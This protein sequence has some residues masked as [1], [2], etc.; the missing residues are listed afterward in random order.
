MSNEEL[1]RFVLK[2]PGYLRTLLPLLPNTEKATHGTYLKE[3]GFQPLDGEALKRALSTS[4][5]SVKRELLLRAIAG[6][7]SPTAA[8]S[9]SL[10]S[11]VALTLAPKVID[12]CILYGSPEKLTKWCELGG[13]HKRQEGWTLQPSGNV[14][15][16]E[17]S[18]P[19]RSWQTLCAAWCVPRD[20]I[21]VSAL[22]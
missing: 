7:M 21:H 11:T 9:R 19:G 1:Q 2:L 16:K 18:S 8:S 22:V 20:A 6:G 17:K 15:A 10:F 3:K 14:S 13:R 12:R 4:D 5:E